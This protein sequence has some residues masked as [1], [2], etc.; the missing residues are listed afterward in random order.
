MPPLHLF[1]FM[2]PQTTD[3]LGIAYRSVSRLMHE[4]SSNGKNLKNTEK[5]VR[6]LLK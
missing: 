5:E 6:Q 3:K 1:S 2:D 4:I